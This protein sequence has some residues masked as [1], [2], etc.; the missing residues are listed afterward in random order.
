MIAMH[1]TVRMSLFSFLLAIT[2][3]FNVLSPAYSAGVFPP[4]ATIY[5]QDNAGV[6]TPIGTVQFAPQP[7]GSALT[8]VTIESDAFNDQF[9]SMRP[10][11]C[12]QGDSE[13]FCHQPYLYSLHNKVTADD[14][15][16]LEYQLLFIRKKPA[17]FGI[18]AWNGLYYKLQLID[19]HVITGT[20]LEGDLN[21]LQSPPADEFGKPIDLTEFIEAN[22]N[23]RL[24]PGLV[25][26]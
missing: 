18:D 20:L 12:L 26:R 21:V 16:D 23:K 5:L 17:D 8:H 22:K 11:K 3:F 13:W 2:G 25:I 1:Q 19:D 24:Y 15:S 4:S 14:L 10:F 6:E 9:L 7:D